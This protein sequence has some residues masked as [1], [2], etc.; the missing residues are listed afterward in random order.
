MAITKKK[1]KKKSFGLVF[2]FHSGPWVVFLSLLLWRFCPSGE[3]F[4]IEI[5]ASTEVIALSEGGTS[6]AMG[7]IE[8]VEA[9][10]IVA[11]G[12]SLA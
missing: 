11:G 4:G 7:V 8:V 3:G 10:S 5:G 6:F 1:K 12:G 9:L 2:T